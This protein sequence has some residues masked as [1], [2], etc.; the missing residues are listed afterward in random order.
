VR[1]LGLLDLAGL[2]HAPEA[3]EEILTIV[4]AGARLG[5]VLHAENGFGPVPETFQG[6][7][8]QVEVRVLQEIEIGDVYAKTV[9]L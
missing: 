3:C 2:Q 8:V 5:V 1:G 9:V 4:G 7:V 6:T